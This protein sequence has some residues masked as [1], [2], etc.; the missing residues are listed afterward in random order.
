MPDYNSPRSL[1]AFLD[2]NR[3]G[4]RKKYGQNFLINPKSRASLIDALELSKDDNVWEVGPGVGAMTALLLEKEATVHA[5]EIDHG[6]SAVLRGEIFK[7]NSRFNLIEGDVLKTWKRN[8]PG[9]YFFGNLPYTVAAKLLC[10]IIEKRRLFRRMV[11]VVQKEVAER[12]FAK[13]GSKNYSS[14][15]V[16]CASAYT[17]T[18]LQVLKGA[19]FYPPPRVDSQGVRLDIRPDA[20]DYPELFYPLVHGLFSSRRKTVKNNLTVFLSLR[21]IL[22]DARDILQA[23]H[24]P[25]N[26]RAETLTV[27]EFAEIA[28][29]LSVSQ[30]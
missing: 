9:R 14:F 16:L 27:A 5:F 10:D 18:P 11:F 7:D 6:F 23:C 19:S 2:A 25:E 17:I 30:S 8:P 20:G 26:A 21:N 3:L 1:K 24:I 29:L 13:P 12:A 4:M 22:T 15:S 28:Q